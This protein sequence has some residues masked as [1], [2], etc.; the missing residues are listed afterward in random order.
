MPA[1]FLSSRFQFLRYILIIIM[2]RA[3]VTVVP[4][5]SLKKKAKKEKDFEVV[6]E[7]FFPIKIFNS[8]LE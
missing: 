1:F 3:I 8:C 7:F 5:L 6:I 2:G 4:L